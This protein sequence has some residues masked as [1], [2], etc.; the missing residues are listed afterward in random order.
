MGAFAASL[1]LLIV[2]TV[3][4]VTE[5]ARGGDGPV[6]ASPDVVGEAARLTEEGGP[7]A[8]KEAQLRRR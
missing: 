4:T 1:L 3:F 8:G 2:A 6:A 7:W 5:V